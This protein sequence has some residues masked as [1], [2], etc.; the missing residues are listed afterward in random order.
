M[1]SASWAGFRRPSSTQASKVDTLH[2]RLVALVLKHIHTLR[3]V[4]KDEEDD[5]GEEEDEEDEE[6]GFEKK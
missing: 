6:K 5:E 2:I 1:G 4:H 3:H